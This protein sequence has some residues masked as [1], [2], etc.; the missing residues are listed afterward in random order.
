MTAVSVERV[1]ELAAE[2]QIAYQ[3]LRHVEKRTEE[4]LAAFDRDLDLA[5]KRYEMA[6]RA[7][8]ELA[9]GEDDEF[10]KEL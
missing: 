2:Y 5:R 8:V 4:A 7:F 3:Q 1:A 9:L 6:R 10:L